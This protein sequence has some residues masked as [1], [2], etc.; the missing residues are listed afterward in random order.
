M[1]QGGKEGGLMSQHALIQG[2]LDSLPAQTEDEFAENLIPAQVEAPFVRGLTALLDALRHNSSL[3]ATVSHLAR[4]SSH[5][6]ELRLYSEW[7]DT[8]LRL[9]A[10]Q[11]ADV[12][13]SAERLG[14]S[15]YGAITGLLGGARVR[16]V[17][18]I[19]GDS[20]PEG[21]GEHEWTLPEEKA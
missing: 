18:L 16:I 2:D 9:W 20:V 7:D 17:G 13:T 15:V 6:F 4:T 11:L 8:A 1:C 21:A 19:A 10:L 14:D 3:V 5:D 12:S